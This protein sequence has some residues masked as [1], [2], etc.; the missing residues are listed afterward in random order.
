MRRL[1]ASFTASLKLCVYVYL[2]NLR[3]VMWFCITLVAMYIGCPMLLRSVAVLPCHLGWRTL[4][5]CNKTNHACLGV[6]YV[7]SQKLQLTFLPVQRARACNGNRSPLRFLK[8]IARTK[9]SVTPASTGKL[10]SYM[11]LH[12]CM[13]YD[14]YTESD[15][16]P[17]RS[18]RLSTR[19]LMA[20]LIMI[21]H[22]CMRMD[23]FTARVAAFKQIL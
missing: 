4:L 11:I 12:V 5:K 23:G 3:L 13:L 2:Q 15:K 21:L 16:K 17:H 18:K 20:G 22:A 10:W 7:I 19:P 6:S 9:G 8:T 1:Q 14:A